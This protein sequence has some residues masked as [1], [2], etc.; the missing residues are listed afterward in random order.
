MA[1]Y[2]VIVGLCLNVDSP[3]ILED[4]KQEGMGYQEVVLA[5]LAKQVAIPLTIHPSELYAPLASRICH[6]IAQFELMQTDAFL[7][8]QFM[9]KFADVD[10]LQG[11]II[12]VVNDRLSSLNV[13]DSLNINQTI[14]EVLDIA[15]D[16][17][18]WLQNV[19]QV[20]QNR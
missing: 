10:I 12:R 11:K 6:A 1:S 14:Y 4:A 16:G 5:D 9:E 2:R 8:H 15:L 7:A 3:H 13:L 19:K 17:G 18:L 20:I